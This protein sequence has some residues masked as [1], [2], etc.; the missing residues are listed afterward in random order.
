MAALAQPSRKPQADAAGTPGADAVDDEYELLAHA[1][2]AY[3]TPGRA[4]P[5]SL[6]L[7]RDS[8]AGPRAPGIAHHETNPGLL[9]PDGDPPGIEST[10]HVSRT[11]NA[12]STEIG[13]DIRHTYVADLKIV[14]VAPDGTEVI[15]R[16]S[17]GGHAQN[18]RRSIGVPQTKRY[19]R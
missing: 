19:G 6:R 16:E 3:R 4:A 14:L 13:V 5:D 7:Q 1:D 18:S 2:R 17:E 11:E 8:I 9:I 10:L 12:K 15:L